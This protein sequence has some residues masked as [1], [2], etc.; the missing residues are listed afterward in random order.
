MR[1]C[2]GLLSCASVLVLSACTNPSSFDT[3]GWEADAG[4]H[5]GGGGGPADV[6]EVGGFEWVKHEKAIFDERSIE[7]LTADHV[8]KAAALSGVADVDPRTVSDEQWAQIIEPRSEFGGYEYRM[9]RRSLIAFATASRAREVARRNRL[10]RGEVLREGEPGAG[11]LGEVLPVAFEPTE[12][13]GLIQKGIVGS[14]NRIL[15]DPSRGTWP[16]AP[17]AAMGSLTSSQCTAFK[18]VNHHTAGTAAHC[19]HTGSGWR[20]R[21]PLR[22]F[23]PNGVSQRP[24]VPADCYWR[25][26]N[27][28]WINHPNLPKNDYAV[29]A[30][31]GGGTPSAWCPLDS[32]DTGF[33]GWASVGYLAKIDGFV[34]GY[35][36]SGLTPQQYGVLDPP[37]PH[38]AY[39]WLNGART[40]LFQPDVL[41]YDND[42]TG[43]QSGSPYVTSTADN[44]YVRA[45]H[46]GEVDF[47]WV[48]HNQGREFNQ[49]VRDFMAAHGGN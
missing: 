26:V 40:K 17:I 30:L 2:N 28:N 44:A 15:I 46:K 34:A 42:T 38:L 24:E 31:R 14:D 22:F 9:A 32:Y 7:E 10:D 48:E 29:L 37:W 6:Y 13:R 35:P 41:K 23:R 33:L 1:Y 27:G 8:L 18:V 47:L 43:G 5:S 21:A 4:V 11:P 19:I 39:H 20:P 36:G 25:T 49:T 12:N 45:I 16:F 3:H